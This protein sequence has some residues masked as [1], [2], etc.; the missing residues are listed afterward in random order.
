MLKTL[1]K[2]RLSSVLTCRKKMPHDIYYGE[3]RG[4]QAR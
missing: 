1:T 4:V 3:K 2:N